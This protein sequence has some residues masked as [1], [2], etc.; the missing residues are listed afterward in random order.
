MNDENQ[1][2]YNIVIEPPIYSELN[3][4]MDLIVACLDILRER[5][6]SVCNF[7]PTTTCEIFVL[8]NFLG[9]S[10]PAI[11]INNIN[12]S[13]VPLD[14]DVLENIVGEII[15]SIGLEEIKNEAILRQKV[16]WDKLKHL[17][18]YSGD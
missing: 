5:L 13:G 17:G 18:H 15:E 4:D 2:G 9:Q 6:Q 7:P 14:N 10:Y 1:K 12:S 8:I 3:W 16:T 11:G